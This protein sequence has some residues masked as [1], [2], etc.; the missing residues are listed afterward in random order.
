MSEFLFNQINLEPSKWRKQLLL[1]VSCL[2]LIGFVEFIGIFKI[3]RKTGEKVIAPILEID[4]KIV[5]VVNEPLWRLKNAYRASYRVK[6]LQQEYSQCLAEAVKID[7]L[8]KENQM[9]RKII[10]DSRDQLDELTVTTPILSLAVP[11]IAGGENHNYVSGSMVTANGTLLGVIDKV[12]ASYSLLTLLSSKKMSPVL[13]ETETGLKGLVVGDG[14]RVLLTELP[15]DEKV[16]VGEKVYT[17]GQPG[18][19]SK[20][21]VG[22]VSQVMKDSAASIQTAVI[23]QYVDFYQQS[24]VEVR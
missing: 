10:N 9:L 14:K 2:L 24:I 22:V 7:Y 13:V 3:I 16:S 4:R 15:I 1:Y 12:S 23:E 6:E 8:E 17:L 19:K 21:L 20:I 11:A 5:S 18:I